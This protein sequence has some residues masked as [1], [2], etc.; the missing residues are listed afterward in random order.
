M[1]LSLE[2]INDKN[3]SVLSLFPVVGSLV[4]GDFWLKIVL[5]RRLASDGL[6]GLPHDWAFPVQLL[7][8]SLLMN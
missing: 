2:R 7:S 1:A 5:I 8:G 6:P 3:F 4:G